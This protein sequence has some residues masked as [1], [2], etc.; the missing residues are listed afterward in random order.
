LSFLERFGLLIDH[1]WNRRENQALARRLHL[2]RVGQE[3]D[4]GAGAEV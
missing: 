3:S 4:R 2:A 1:E